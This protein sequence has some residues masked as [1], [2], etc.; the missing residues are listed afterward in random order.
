MQRTLFLTCLSV[1]LSTAMLSAQPRTM[2]LQAPAVLGA[3]GSY[4]MEYPPSIAGNLFLLA[5]AA[6]NF[7]GAV[8]ITIPGFTVNGLLRV[9]PTTWQTPVAGVL[10]A[11]GLTPSLDFPIPPNP[12]L[13]GATFDVQG[14]DIDAAN[15][16][17]L[18]DDDVEVTIT[19]VPAPGFA[20]ELIPPGTFTRGG[21][22]TG[23]IHD[24]TITRPFWMG[25][26]EVDQATFQSVMG[27]SPSFFTGSNRPVET[28]S[29]NDAVA[30]CNAVNV[31]EALN[32]RL[33]TGYEYRLP[34]EAEWEYACRAGT[35]TS[36]TFGN[37]IGCGLANYSPS[38]FNG[39]V[40]A[41][42]TVG[43]YLPNA[44]GL[45]DVH[46]NVREWCFDSTN[47]NPY[48]YTGTVADPVSTTGANRV[49]RG[50]SWLSSANACRSA[51]RD[52]LAPTAAGS[53]VG[54]RV[55]CAPIL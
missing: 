21:G 47:G 13:V 8:P 51:A 49:I 26:F 14:I 31:T 3:T 44:F 17:T 54:F 23:P 37:T 12:T 39:C 22:G 35:T 40:N 6:P 33:P 48:P 52:L 20:L 32:N 1:T 45:E 43:N 10:D 27:S 15:V 9:D 46:G 50:G 30:F 7:P 4:A 34:T 42:S 2:L 41:T 25:K 18:S 38:P 36:Y 28:I 5:I 16:L 11:S 19:N 53:T 55:V 24:V 29:W